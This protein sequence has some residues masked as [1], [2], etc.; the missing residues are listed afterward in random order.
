MRS[1]ERLKGDVVP[2]S[3]SGH[4]FADVP[5]WSMSKAMRDAV[6]SRKVR[7]TAKPKRILWTSRIS[8]SLQKAE[9]SRLMK[10][11]RRAS[12][13]LTVRGWA[14]ARNTATTIDPGD[15][16][17]EQ[18]SRAQNSGRGLIRTQIDVPPTPPDPNL[19][20]PI[21]KTPPAPPTPTDEPPPEPVE[22]PPAESEPKP[23][24]T[25]EQTRWRLSATRR[26]FLCGSDRVWSGRCLLIHHRVE[27]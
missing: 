4:N 11:S 22:D 18:H 24:Y 1:C 13:V 7:L 12:E 10:P 3:S 26:Q 17:S 2:R 8:R 5:A 19:P 25:V 15:V 9:T 6:L 21:P 27:W 20:L 23:P 16:M 14:V